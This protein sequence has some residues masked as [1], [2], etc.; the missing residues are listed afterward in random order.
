MSQKKSKS[1]IPDWNE[2]NKVGPGNISGLES[3]IAYLGGS[4]ES[5]PPL[6]SSETPDSYPI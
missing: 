6:P 5:S 4:G 3:M 2:Y 1:L